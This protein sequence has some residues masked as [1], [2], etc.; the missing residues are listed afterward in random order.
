MLLLAVGGCS[1]PTED[2]S[3]SDSEAVPVSPKVTHVEAP[4]TGVTIARLAE[5]M[6]GTP[7]AYGG[8]TPEGF[9]CS[10]LVYYTHTRVGL[11][12]PRTA[13]DQLRASAVVSVE[14]LSP[15]DLVF[16]RTGPKISHV[17]IYIGERQFIHA[18]ETGR[19]VE[20]T[21]LDN[22]YYRARLIRAGRL[23]P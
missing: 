14:S 23:Y 21:S 18:P 1:W 2:T 8:H 22:E 15:G 17:G 20:Y 6:L 19:V 10:G 16:F 4:A 12:V 5:S 11:S 3:S 13:A 9:D 7:Y